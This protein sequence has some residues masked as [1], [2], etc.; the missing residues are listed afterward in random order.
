MI[1]TIPKETI[2]KATD[3]RFKTIEL[4]WNHHTSHQHPEGL[5]VRCL[6]V[7]H[8]T[9]FLFIATKAEVY[10]YSLNNFK[11]LKSFGY[12]DQFPSTFSSGETFKWK[13]KF[14]VCVELQNLWICNINKMG[15]IAFND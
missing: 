11:L 15:F 7:N 3:H 6:A 4:N 1:R 12:V 2:K 13:I 14:V 9:D 5:K 8:I 10:L